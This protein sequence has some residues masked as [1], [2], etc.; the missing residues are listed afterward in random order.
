M[1]NY[2]PSLLLTLFLLLTSSPF[3]FAAKSPFETSLVPK[4]APGYRFPVIRQGRNTCYFTSVQIALTSRSKASIRLTKAMEEVGFD[5]SR[6]A[7]PA[8]QRAFEKLLHFSVRTDGHVSFLQKA[9]S[10]GRPVLVSSMLKVGRK[11]FP[12]VTVAYSFDREGVWVSDPYTAS[13][14]RL[15]WAAIF[16]QQGRTRYNR[17]REP[18]FKPYVRWSKSEKESEKKNDFWKSEELLK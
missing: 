1:K 10:E 16:D 15:P 14:K 9:L 4:Y 11:E 6:L 13:R 7:Y 12:H 8:D 17:L 18:V 2:F 3:V 5:G